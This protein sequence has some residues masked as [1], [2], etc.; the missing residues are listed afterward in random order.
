MM[1]FLAGNIRLLRKKI[2]ET[3][4]GIGL[5]VNKGQTTIGNWENGKSEP[6][7]GEL[8]IL[9]NFF[10]ISIDLLI[11]V[12]LSATDN[13]SSSVNS[14]EERL[15]ENKL[16][17]YS[18]DRTESMVKEEEAGAALNMIFREIRSLREELRQV[19]TSM[20]KKSR[21][22]P[23]KTRVTRSSRSGSGSKRHTR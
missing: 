5:L 4:T 9:S 10:G 13:P 11:K 3:Q 12:D 15:R 19:K 17:E 18:F 20:K 8:L 21:P 23:H 2:A 22:S 6:N 7:I 14:R 1:N 16:P